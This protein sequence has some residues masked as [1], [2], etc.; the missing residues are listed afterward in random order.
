MDCRTSVSVVVLSEANTLLLHK[1]EDFRIWSLPG[2]FLEPGEDWQEAAVREVHEETGYRIAVGRLIG[3]Y[4]Q[5]QMPNGGERKLVCTGRIV[6]GEP[7]E[8]GAETVQV[9]WF[10]V[11]DLPFSLTRF[12]RTYIDDAL[13]NPETP[14][15]R[16]LLMPRWKAVAITWLL[17][18]RD[19]RNWLLRRSSRGH[20]R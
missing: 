11:E 5:P 3:E 1:R 9:R 12:M 2:G 13:S 16:T 18:L 20:N 17:R 7:I 6:G 14:V 8:R 10:A 15:S 4:R 19:C